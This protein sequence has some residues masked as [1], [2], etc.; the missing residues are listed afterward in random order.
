MRALF[1]LALVGACAEPPRPPPQR[2]ADPDAV[3]GCRSRKMPLGEMRY[4]CPT[5]VM[6]DTTQDPRPLHRIAGGAAASAQKRGWTVSSR[7]LDVPGTEDAVFVQ[8]SGPSQLGFDIFAVHALDTAQRV[9]QCHVDDVDSTAHFETRKAACARMFEAL[10]ARPAP[11][12]PT[13]TVDCERAMNHLYELAATSKTGDGP[14]V[15]DEINRW[16]A[17]CTNQSAACALAA[18]TYVEATVCT[19]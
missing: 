7:R 12:G 10:L 16:G 13:I 19:D 14:D 18:T 11:T 8:Y 1:V 2:P 4:T 15:H 3:N 9:I 6:M 5:L 17:R